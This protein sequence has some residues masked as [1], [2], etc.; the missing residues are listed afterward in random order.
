M[1]SESDDRGGKSGRWLRR[2]TRK[3]VA[4]PF[5]IE[6]FRAARLRHPV[7]PCLSRLPH[8]NTKRKRPERFSPR[9]FGLLCL[10]GLEVEHLERSVTAAR[11][12]T[13]TTT[14]GQMCVHWTLMVA[15]GSS[16]VNLSNG[17]IPSFDRAMNVRDCARRGREVRIGCRVRLSAGP[18]V[19]GVT[20]EVR[21]RCDPTNPSLPKPWSRA[22]AG[23]RYGIPSLRK[24]IP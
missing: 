8:A 4:E 21:C 22:R 23:A 11:D 16:A 2:E 1:T 13:T 15:S 14:S 24:Y 12:R 17:R 7:D 5:Q 9:A 19:T 20:C 18:P 6:G 3:R 10:C